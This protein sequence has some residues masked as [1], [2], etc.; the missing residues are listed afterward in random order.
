M[1]VEKGGLLPTVQVNSNLQGKWYLFK[2]LFGDW[3]LL[4]GMSRHV[5]QK[6][7]HK[8]WIWKSFVFSERTPGYRSNFS[9][10]WLPRLRRPGR[11]G[12]KS[13]GRVGNRKP[14]MPSRKQL[15][16]SRSRLLPSNS[17]IFRF[18]LRN[19]TNIKQIEHNGYAATL[20]FLMQSRQNLLD[21]LDFSGDLPE[22]FPELHLSGTFWIFSIES[23]HQLIFTPVFCFYLYVKWDFSNPWVPLE[24]CFFNP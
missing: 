2:P 16:F 4:W 12:P 9:E 3:Q 6:T 21:C 13:W 24:F 14:L 11:P 15:T 20:S 18:S 22:F 7:R 10:P 1:H 17:D 19:S 8:M 5:T 23:I